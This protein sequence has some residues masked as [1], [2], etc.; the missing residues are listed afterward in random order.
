MDNSGDEEE[1]DQLICVCGRLIQ[2]Y[3]EKYVLKTPCMTSSQTSFI[4]LMEVLQGSESRCYNMFRMDKRVFVML[5]NDL[6]NNY[7]LKGSRNISSA[8]ILGIFLYILGQGI[9]NRNAQD[10]FQRSSETV[11]RYFDVMLD[12]LYEMAKVMIKPLDPEFRSTL[13]EILSDSRYM[14]HFKGG[15]ALFMI[16]EYSYQ[17]NAILNQIF[18]NLQMGV[19]NQHVTKKYLIMHI[20]HLEA[21]LS[22]LL[23]YEKKWSILRDMPSYSYEKQ[24]KIVITRMA[25]RNYI[26]RYALRDRDFD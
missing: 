15:K 19:K 6:E 10:R 18:Q 5:M 24:V 3:L 23:G 2:V 4:W 16:V 25:L 13:Q 9:G 17:L 20:L 22:A 7:K 8:E 21:S 12:I 11:S 26:R 1:I 14:S